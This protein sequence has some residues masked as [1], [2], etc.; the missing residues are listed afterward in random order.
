MVLDSSTVGTWLHSA[1]GYNY[2]AHVQLDAVEIPGV[3]QAKIGH[4][5]LTLL[6]PVTG[7]VFLE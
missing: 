4:I 7:L 6:A 3:Y 2:P 5:L 1:F